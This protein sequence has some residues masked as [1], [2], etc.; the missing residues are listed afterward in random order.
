MVAKKALQVQALATG[1]YILE[2]T[3][4]AKTT[5]YVCAQ[6]PHGEVK[7]SAQLASGDYGA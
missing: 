1:I 7:I 6:T 2:I 5:F 3:D 4:T